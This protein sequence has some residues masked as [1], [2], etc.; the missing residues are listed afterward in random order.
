MR[1]LIAFAFAFV[2]AFAVL[3]AQPA[4]AMTIKRVVSPGGIEAWLVQDSSLPLIA[5]NFSFAGG[6]TED[7]DTKSGTAYMVSSMLDEGAGPLDSKAYHQQLEDNAVELSFSVNHDYFQGSIKLLKD[8][9]DKSFELLRLALNEAKF[10]PD[11]TVRVREQV[12][13]ALRRETTD[14]GSIANRAWWSTA[15]EGHPYARP[16]NGTLIS[17]P[18]ITEDDMR[19]YTRRVFTRGHLKVAAVGDIDPETLGKV[20]DRVFGALPA[21]GTLREVADVTVHDTGRRI[22]SQL[23]VPQAV[24]RMGG[25]GVPR[26][27][28]D[29]MAAYLVNHILGGGSFTSRLYDQVREKRGL[30]YG[31]TSYL[32]NLRHSPLFMVSTQTSAD[33]TRE[34][35]E[36]IEQQVAQMVADGPTAEELA[37]AKSYLKG[38]YALNFDTSTKIAAMLLQIQIDDVG[39]DYI[40]KRSALIDSVSVEDT[41]RVAKRLAPTGLLTTVVGQPKNLASKEPRG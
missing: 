35:L 30:V 40:E 3:P 9:Q 11:A 34:A 31:V 6:S 2:A 4:A 21:T 8:R 17:V 1:C 32:T 33:K 27:D 26:K 12:L 28:P 39:I 10:V 5:M 36:L 24:I 37:K 20:L 18:T 14:P 15:F 7:P 13:S 16:N 23:A 25:N 22:V 29:F 41:R 19:D 38:A